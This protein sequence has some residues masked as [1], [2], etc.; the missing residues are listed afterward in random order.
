MLYRLCLWE[1]LDFLDLKQTS[2]IGYDLP[3]F[4]LRWGVPCCSVHPQ[5]YK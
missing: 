4:A 1:D 2:N 3:W 5:A